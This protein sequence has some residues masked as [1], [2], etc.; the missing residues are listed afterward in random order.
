MERKPQRVIRIT[1]PDGRVFHYY[2]I[3]NLLKDERHTFRISENWLGRC[4]R[5]A[6]GVN[7]VSKVSLRGFDFEF[8]EVI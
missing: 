4:R 2:S 6:V 5:Q 1:C 3:R 7:G 8:F